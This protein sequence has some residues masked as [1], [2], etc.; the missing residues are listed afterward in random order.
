MVSGFESIALLIGSATVMGIAAQKLGQP[1]I[2]AYILAGLALGPVGFGLV[3]GTE[4]IKFFSELGLAF[5]LFLIGLEIDLGEVREV[6]S[7]T[8][9]IGTLQMFLTFCIG[10]VTVFI[11][12]FGLTASLLVGAIVMFSSTALVVKTLSSMDESSTLP[13]RLDIGVLLVQDI[14]V[15]VLIALLTVNFSNPVEVMVKLIEI[16]ALISIIGLASVA[17]SRYFFSKVMKR[18]S[19]NS[20]A[21]FTHGLAWAFGFIWLSQFFHLSAEIGAFLAGIGLAQLPYS[22]E[23]QEK[24][25]PLT[26]LFMAI[27]F[28]NFGL[29]ITGEAIY[30]YLPEAILASAVIVASKFLILF[31]LI[32]RMKFTPDTSFTAAINMTQISEFGLVLTAIAISEGFLSPEIT[33]FVS[34]LAIFTM[35]TSAYLIKYSESIK[36]RAESLL[37]LFDSDEKEDVEV[38]VLEGHAVV[39]GY[40]E[41]AR[42]VC[43]KLDER[44]QV[45]VI[46]RNSE[47]TKELSSSSYE[48]IY[49]D[50]KHGKIRDGA[51][52]SEASFV[53]SFSDEMEV[54]TRIL[55]ERGDETVAIVR[56]ESFEDASELYDLEADYVILENLIAGNRL[57]EYL[58]L[59][60]E[61]REVFMKETEPEKD[62]IQGEDRSQS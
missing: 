52:I 58:E 21:F 5:L 12:G 42:R 59:Y 17:S 31:L 55:E 40:D 26:D 18:I 53:L 6:F 2:V 50:F 14:A 34:M 54:N 7:E 4:A 13:G 61:D 20:L 46:D 35:G 10:T 8:V 48:Y 27:F 41:M 39:V 15:V 43:S 11:L 45:L 47:N 56:A 24:V 25:R 22:S 1:K 38:N 30:T 37:N 60:L 29:G 44:Y 62:Y 51:N 3:Y 32:D 57:S 23:L 33:G 19:D 9:W 36:K 49:G 16:L 28:V